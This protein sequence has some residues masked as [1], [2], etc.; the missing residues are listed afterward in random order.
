M[1]LAIIMIIFSGA[2]LATLPFYWQRR[3]RTLDKVPSWWFWGEQLWYG[4]VRWAPTA[5]IWLF[6]LSIFV[7]TIKVTG[8]SSE[9]NKSLILGLIGAAVL[10]SPLLLGVTILLFNWPKQLV[11]PHL[12]S[13]S[14]AL[15]V[16]LKK[17][18]RK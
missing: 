10:L 4:W 16:W 15:E 5:C 9:E 14:G 13:Q 3:V 1:A 12:R 11:F 8:Y 18:Q 7:F 17:N 2:A 6:L